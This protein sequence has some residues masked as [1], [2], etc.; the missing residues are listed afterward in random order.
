[1]LIPCLG[2]TSLVWE[3]AA[4][5]NKLE[6]TNKV[7][8]FEYTWWIFCSHDSADYGLSTCLIHKPVVNLLILNIIYIYIYLLKH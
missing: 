2:M 6:S 4:I 8:T 5:L 1:M 3:P 7:I